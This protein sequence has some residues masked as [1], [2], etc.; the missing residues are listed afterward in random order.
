MATILVL[1]HSTAGAGRLGAT[2]RD[3]AFKLDTRKPALP[4]DRG[5]HE[6]PSDLDG[7]Q[8]LVSLGGPAQPDQNDPW[9]LQEIELIKEAHARELPLIGICLGHQ[10]I[11]RALG[12]E[13][14]RQDK[15]EWGFMPVDLTVPGQTDT[16]LAGVPWTTPMFQSHAYAVTKPPPGATVLARSKGCPN[17]IMRI[18]QRTIGF[19]FHFEADAKLLDYFAGTDADLMA[20]VG[21]N[22]S[23]FAQQRQKHYEMFARVADRLC[24]NLVSFAFNFRS[25]TQV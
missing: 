17:Q 11:G 23:E 6:L 7:Y 21:T 25:L 20:R 13:V 16:L 19:Q 3:H 12:G 22:E 5:G 24:I 18:G 4:L 1:Q 14:A 10:L 8:G 15:P 9:M 2:L